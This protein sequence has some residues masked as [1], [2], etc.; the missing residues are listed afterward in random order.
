MEVVLGRARQVKQFMKR[1]NEHV[2]INLSH[3]MGDLRQVEERGQSG[4]VLLSAF[5]ANHVL[6]L[7]HT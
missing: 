5:P 6:A 4:C 2:A 1:W 7:R 3:P